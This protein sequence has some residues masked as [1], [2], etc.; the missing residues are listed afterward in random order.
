VAGPGAGARSRALRLSLLAAFAVL[1]AV[2]AL[3]VFVLPDIVAGPAPRAVRAPDAAPGR[4]GD[5]LAPPLPGVVR[6]DAETALGGALRHRARLE[7]S[8]VALWG[9]PRLAE[10]RA[11]LAAGDAAFAQGDFAGA[12]RAYA[13]ADALFQAL[14]AR[15]PQVHAQALAAGGQAL[16]GGDGATAREHFE[17]ALSIEPEDGDARLGLERAST[18]EEVHALH[19]EAL[20]REAAGD[21]HGAV[22]ALE[23]AVAMDPHFAPAAGTLTRVRAAVAE[24]DFRAAM[25]DALA[26]LGGGRLAAARTALARA[27]VV[28]PVDPA[29]VDAA[30]RLDEADRVV[31]IDA[32]REKARVLER[33]ERWSDAAT[34]YGAVLAIDGQAA[35]ALDG[36]ARAE[37][38][39]RLHE[40]IDAHLASPDR[41]AHDGPFADAGR[42]LAEVATLPDAGPALAGLA[43]RLRAAL[44]TA[45][46]PVPVVIR[47]DGLTDVTLY[48]IGRFG[49]LL[50]RTVPLRPGRYVARGTRAGYRDVRREFTVSAGEPAPVILVR[51]EEPI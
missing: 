35:F 48:R 20:A 12:R 9:G 8:G 43:A 18:I 14:L 49:T 7:A 22:N 21:L 5:P 46:A 1:L 23:R 44:A 13:E 25:S 6:R 39:A 38:R 41:L 31:R 3:V 24:G 30:R 29:L 26:A 10:A 11:A 16:A 4:D 17:V 19:G 42:L 28:R 33:D 27:R 15:R 51:C 34:T 36:R 47:S 40:A 2:A 32:L 37:A 50:E 45:R